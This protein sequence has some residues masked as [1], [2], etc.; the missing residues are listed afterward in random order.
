MT[1]I[2]AEYKAGNKFNS[3]MKK[4]TLDNIE[5]VLNNHCSSDWLKWALRSSLKRDP[6]DS[7]N[8]SEILEKILTMRENDIL[9]NNHEILKGSEFINV[10]K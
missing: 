7:A 2:Q 6:V 8:D 3:G 1:E 5:T 9:N 4:E 10:S